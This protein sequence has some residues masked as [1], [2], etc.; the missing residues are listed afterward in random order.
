M[1]YLDVTDHDAG[2]L[3]RHAS[4]HLPDGQDPIFTS[5]GSDPTNGTAII[6]VNGTWTTDTIQNIINNYTS[7]ANGVFYIPF[8]SSPLIG[9]AFTH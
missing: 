7:G 6:F 8:G 9:Q 3:Q 5:Q 4:S 1:V 2:Q